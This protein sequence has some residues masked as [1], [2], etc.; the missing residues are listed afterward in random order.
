LKPFIIR[1][2][3]VSSRCFIAGAAAGA[4]GIVID[5]YTAFDYVAN[6]QSM[7]PQTIR[8]ARVGCVFF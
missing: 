2:R 3:I 8:P 1:G 6:A 5:F 7:G 4:E